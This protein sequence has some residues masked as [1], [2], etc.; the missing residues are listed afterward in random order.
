MTLKRAAV[1]AATVAVTQCLTVNILVG[2][3]TGGEVPTIVNLFTLATASVSTVVAVQAEFHNR[4][5]ERLSAM[6]D[7][8][9]A[10]LAE[11][12]ERTSDHNTG[13]VEGY[14]LGH[15]RDST[16]RPL[17]SPGHGRRTD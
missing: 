8:L 5:Q 15:E 3:L 9:I 10:R 16:V 6:T 7:F 4:T 17:A 12:D 14:L 13:F 1:V 11:I 2:A